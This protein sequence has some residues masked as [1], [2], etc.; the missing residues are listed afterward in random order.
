[1]PTDERRDIHATKA[2]VDARDQGRFSAQEKYVQSPTQANIT[3]R[4]AGR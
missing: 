4:D 1:M 2:Q 3:A